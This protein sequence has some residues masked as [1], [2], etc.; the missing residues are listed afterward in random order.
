MGNL[1]D[2]GVDGM[3]KIIPKWEDGEMVGMELREIEAGS[4]YDKVGLSD[5][6]VI[7]SFN[8]IDLNSPA[9]GARVVSQF[10]EADSFSIELLGGET[11]DIPAEELE[12]FLGAGGAD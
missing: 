5:G 3:A 4:L 11:M 9:A 7:K 2:F 10:V 1:I 6:D 8:G 12:H